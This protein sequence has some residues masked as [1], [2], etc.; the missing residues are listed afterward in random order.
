MNTPFDLIDITIGEEKIQAR[1]IEWDY[2]EN[3]NPDMPTKYET[4]C[5]ACSQMMHFE[6]FEIMAPPYNYVICNNCGAGEMADYP[7]EA[8]EADADAVQN[9]DSLGAEEEIVVSSSTNKLRNPLDFGYPLDN[10]EKG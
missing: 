8:E 10:I 6:A 3:D 2:D 7:V 9:E 1:P 4:T 5:P